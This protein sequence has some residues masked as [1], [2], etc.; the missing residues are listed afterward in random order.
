M[1]AKQIRYR[2]LLRRSFDTKIT[3]VFLR[4]MVKPYRDVAQCIKFTPHSFL[5]VPRKL[6]TR[7]MRR[8]QD[9]NRDIIREPAR[10]KETRVG[11][12]TATRMRGTQVATRAVGAQGVKSDESRASERRVAPRS[13]RKGR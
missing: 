1:R 13:V 7:G 6:I 9:A 2:E 8:I 10:Y 5:T 3:W 12:K 4:D 11:D